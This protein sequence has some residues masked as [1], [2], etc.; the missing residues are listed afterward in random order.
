MF[1]LSPAGNET[2]LHSFTGG[3]DGGDPL[4][5][6]ILDSSGNI[7]G[8]TSEGGVYG[9]GVVFDLDVTGH[10]TVL[11]T[12]T[13]GADG[14]EPSVEPTQDSSGNL[15]GTTWSG[16]AFGWGAAFK[17]SRMRKET[18][19]YSF[20]GGADGAPTTAVVPGPS[21]VFYG[22]TRLG[23]A[24]GYGV[25]FA[26]SVSGEESVLY[27]FTGGVDGG[28]PSAGMIRDSFGRFMARL[29]AAALTARV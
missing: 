5:G 10:E 25:V 18:V 3:P 4:A 7:F 19:L 17:V 16:G 20:T 24:N 27:D 21:G 13:N 29:S 6:L 23:G 2:V 11:Y 28:W 14:G 12:F 26:L 9:Y 15:Y 1:E 22:A 8:T